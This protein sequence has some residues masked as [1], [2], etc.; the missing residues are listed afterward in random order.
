M[1][2]AELI[3]KVFFS[4]VN[5][6]YERTSSW[7]AQCICRMIPL[8]FF[9]GGFLAAFCFTKTKACLYLRLQIKYGSPT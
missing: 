4:V 5:R 3:F 1:S 6:F 7:T 8:V 9:G 2:E